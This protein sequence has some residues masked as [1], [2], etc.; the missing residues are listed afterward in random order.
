[1]RIF[2]S[3]LPNPQ[4][5]DECGDFELN[6]VPSLTLPSISEADESQVGDEESPLKLQESDILPKSP[7]TRTLIR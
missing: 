3:L 7:R 4:Q 5:D 1:M 6:R 2:C